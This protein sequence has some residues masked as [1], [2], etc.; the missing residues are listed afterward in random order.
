LLWQLLNDSL[1]LAY[2]LLN[3][4][5]HVPPLLLTHSWQKNPKVYHQH[6]LPPLFLSHIPWAWPSNWGFNVVYSNYYNM[7]LRVPLPTNRPSI[8]HGLPL[9]IDPS[10][11]S[12]MGVAICNFII[13]DPSSS[14][15]SSFFMKLFMVSFGISLPHAFSLQASSTFATSP[16]TRSQVTGW[17]PLEGLTKSSCRKLRLGGMLLTSNSRKG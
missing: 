11:F 10:I 16:L 1:Q 9:A 8:G 12:W 14:Y 4:L 6:V 17:N 15:P 5:P 7:A 3:Y 2:P 13:V